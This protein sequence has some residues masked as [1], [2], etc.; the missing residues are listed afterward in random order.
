M[1]SCVYILLFM[2]IYALVYV[3]QQMQWRCHNY[4]EQAPNLKPTNGIKVSRV[5][6]PGRPPTHSKSNFYH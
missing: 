1:P 3:A 5:S 4:L 6:T 2:G